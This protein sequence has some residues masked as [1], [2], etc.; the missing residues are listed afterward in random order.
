M[1]K[2][3]FITKLFKP[4][5]YLLA[6]A[7]GVLVYFRIDAYNN[8]YLLAVKEINLFLT[9]YIAFLFVVAKFLWNFLYRIRWLGSYID[10][11]LLPNISG[12]W[13]ATVLS[14][15]KDAPE[16]GVIL[17]IE[18]ELTPINFGMKAKSTNK[19]LTSHLLTYDIEKDE[20]SEKFIVI[21]TFEARVFQPASTDSPQFFGSARLEYCSA[22]KEFSGVYWT[23]RAYQDER[24]TAG[25]IRIRKQEN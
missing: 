1:F 21:Y 5:T 12:M 25:D 22:S 17:E 2:L 13:E 24:Q 3:A 14:K 4:I 19:D 7:L 8:D 10:K 23:N 9:G 15:D 11:N 16:S 18:M 20:K 6:L